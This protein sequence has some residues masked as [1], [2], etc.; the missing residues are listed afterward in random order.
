MAPTARQLQDEGWRV[1]CA[2]SSADAVVDDSYDYIENIS[3]SRSPADI[4]GNSRAFTELRRLLIDRTYDV[5]HV[6]T[7]IASFIV[8]AAI[9]T[10]PREKRPAVVY[11]AHGFHF[12]EGAPIVNNVVYKGLEKLASRWTDVLCVVNEED[13]AAA[14]SLRLASEDRIIR[15]N[16]VGIDL[17][18]FSPEAVGDEAVRRVRRDLGL[19]EDDVLFTVVAELSERKRPEDVIQALASVPDAHL[20]L[21]GNGPLRSML[22]RL[23]TALNLEDRVHFLG[24]RDDIPSLVRA[25]DALVLVSSQEGL[26]TCVIEAL[27]LRVPVIGTDVRGTRDLI[28]K[29]GGWLVP[30]G[31]IE[32]LSSAMKEVSSGVLPKE[33]PDMEPFRLENIVQ[34]YRHAYELALSN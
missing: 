27:A 13:M 6:M 29:G 23:V 22:E 11:A 19:R 3:W 15:L 16:G 21:A 25:S 8:R 34:F 2:V 5:V 30:L 17:R 4:A 9:A 12:Y 33:F 24:F 18:M 32:A 7:P 26:P 28:A 14:K 1:E 10:L 31:D 20:A